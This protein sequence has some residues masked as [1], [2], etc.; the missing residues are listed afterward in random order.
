[1]RV[2]YMLR[3]ANYFCGFIKLFFLALIFF[4]FIFGVDLF[5]AML[6]VENLVRVKGQE[7]TVVQG[8]GIVTGLSG[9]G[10]D[11][12]NFSPT[13]KSILQMLTRSGLAESDVR[14]ISASRNC[15]LVEV[16]ATVPSVG[17]RSGELLDCSVTAVG[18][19][20]S[21]AGGRLSQMKL[22]APIPLSPDESPILGMAWGNLAEIQ[23]KPNNAFI[24]KGCRLTADFNNPY[25]KDGCVTLV[26]RPEHADMRMA[27]NIASSINNEFRQQNRDIAKA[28]DGSYVVVRVPTENCGNPMKFMDQLLATEVFI[29]IPIQPQVLIDEKSG[30]IIIDEDVQIKP[31]IISHSNFEVEIRPPVNPPEQEINPQR[32]VE[33]DSE[34]KLKQ[35]NGEAVTNKKLKALQALMDALRLPP[36]DMI[37]IIKSLHQKGAIIGDVK[38]VG[39]K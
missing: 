22:F 25:I 3:S 2:D 27:F 31:V 39:S 33:A 35:F 23:G 36:K 9:T 38:Y 13:A 26:L 30:T 20:K 17:A 11:L 5:G 7:G 8:Y 15:A 29:N 32:F 16:S 4:V 18:N 14:A 37:D 19:A 1:M 6:R 21:L 28:V 10:D 12:K 34:T 24:T